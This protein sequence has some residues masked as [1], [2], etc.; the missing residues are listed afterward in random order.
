MAGKHNQIMPFT[1]AEQA[2]LE[3]LLK[4]CSDEE[5]WLV[6]S[7]VLTSS[8]EPQMMEI[9]STSHLTGKKT[10]MLWPTLDN[11]KEQTSL[12]VCQEPLRLLEPKEARQSIFKFSELR[13]PRKLSRLAEID[14]L[15]LELQNENGHAVEAPPNN[16]RPSWK[17]DKETGNEC[18][19]PI[20]P[21]D[22]VL[23]DSSEVRGEIAR[24][25]IID[26]ELSLIQKEN[27]EQLIAIF[28]LL[29]YSAWILQRRRLL[30]PL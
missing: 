7:Q 12:S 19:Q 18:Q 25:R 13:S 16:G 24:L 20:R 15:L 21:G 1:D 28:A 29:L 10:W 23:N 26:Q 3:Y 27:S 6:D 8:K 14:Q 9:V 17:D 30:A 5:D 2:R 4:E 11:A 22:P